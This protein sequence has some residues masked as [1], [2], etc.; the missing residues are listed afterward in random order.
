MRHRA[1][2][3]ACSALA[4][5]SAAILRSAPAWAESAV[6]DGAAELVKHEQPLPYTQPYVHLLGALAIGR[7]LRLNNPY[8][9]QTELGATGQS[10]SLTASYADVSAA[11][12]LGNPDGLQQGLALHWS[13]ALSGIAQDVLT[14]SYIALVR[15]PPRWLLY[16]RAGT[17]LVL[18]PDPSVGLE[19]GAGGAWLASAGLGVTAEFVGSLFYGA[20]TEQEPVT[21]IPILSLQVGVIVDYEVLP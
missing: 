16:G 5:L 6:G 7:G 20:A 9:L 2:V 3:R 21:V 10:L 13:A 15:L 18:F 4:V 8:R 1:S 19:L 14:P 11:G 17:P 12:L